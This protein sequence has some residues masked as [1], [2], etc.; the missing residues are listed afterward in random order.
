MGDIIQLRTSLLSLNYM[1]TLLLT[2]SSSSSS[3]S[4]FISWLWSI[5]S[6]WSDIYHKYLELQVTCSNTVQMH[7]HIHNI[8]IR[9]WTLFLLYNVSC[10]HERWGKISVGN[11]PM[12]YWYT[13]TDG[14]YWGS[15]CVVTAFQYE[16]IHWMMTIWMTQEWGNSALYYNIRGKKHLYRISN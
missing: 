8:H 4:S 14:N 7:S 2:T 1:R 13:T 5:W 10:L 11:N 12:L 15:S 6:I 3:S 9:I 16:C